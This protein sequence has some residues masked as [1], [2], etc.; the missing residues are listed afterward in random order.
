MLCTVILLSFAIAIA[1]NMCLKFLSAFF[2]WLGCYDLP[3]QAH[4]GWSFP[5]P[6]PACPQC[7]KPGKRVY[8][9]PKKLG[10][11]PP[12]VDFRL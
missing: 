1:W 12:T 6:S 7:R 8:G 11:R 2:Q 5:P 3:C 4:G 9:A 10:Y